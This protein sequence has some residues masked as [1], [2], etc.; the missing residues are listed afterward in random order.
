[1]TDQTRPAQQQAVL[2]AVPKQLYIGGEWRDG[3]GGET[4]AVEDPATGEDDRARSP[5]PRRRTRSTRSA[6]PHDAWRGDWRASAPRE[7]SDILRRAYEAVVARTDELALLMTLEMGKPLA[8]SE[9]EIAYGASFLR[10][11]AE[12]AVRIDG[13]FATHEAGAGP[14]ADDEAA[15]RAVRLHHAV[16]LPAGDGHA[17]DRPGGRGRLHDGRQAGQADAAVDAHARADPRGG[18]AAGGRAE[19][20]HRELERLGDGAADP[21]PAHAQ[22][23]VH[24]LDRG[25]PHAHRAVRRAGPEGL[26]GA[27]R[28]RAVRRLRGRRRR[29]R[30][31]GRDGRQDAQHRRGV[32]GR[33][34][35]P[36]RASRSPP[37]S[38]TSSPRGWAR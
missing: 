14:A 23:V 36:R 11:Y 27:R 31:R 21:R 26:D 1:M 35:L 19:R 25:R 16:E 28:Q 18:R 13:R 37:S 6:P 30:G 9:A 22:A 10:W 24:R 3:A 29:R 38:P 33:Q 34:P 32:H 8:E 20:R 15:R 7:R 12:E 2:D 5:T 17:Q 4:L